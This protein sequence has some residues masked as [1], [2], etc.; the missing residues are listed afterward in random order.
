[1]CVSGSRGERAKMA[2]AILG[3]QVTSTEKL[4]MDKFIIGVVV[5]IVVV[6]LSCLKGLPSHP[7]AEWLAKP[8]DG[9]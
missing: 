3:A 2:H 6:V 9:V 4:D 1:M 5:I 7:S 8:K